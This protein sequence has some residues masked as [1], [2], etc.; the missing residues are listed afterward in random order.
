M[1]GEEGRLAGYFVD[2]SPLVNTLSREL[3]HGYWKVP[4]WNGV[5]KEAR[6]H[7]Q[8]GEIGDQVSPQAAAESRRSTR[9]TLESCRSDSDGGY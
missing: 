6:I 7:V 3:V 8:G 4:S 1:R 2:N 5:A 9:V